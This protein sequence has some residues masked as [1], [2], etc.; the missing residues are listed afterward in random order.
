MAIYLILVNKRTNLHMKTMYP[1]PFFSQIIACLILKI[2][3][4]NMIK[5]ELKLIFQTNNEYFIKHQGPTTGTLFLLAVNYIMFE[6][7]ID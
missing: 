6:I 3:P 7:K 4:K 5:H 1:R 2:T